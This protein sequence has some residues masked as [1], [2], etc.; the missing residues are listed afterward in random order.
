MA[1]AARVAPISQD[2]S[3]VE[4]VAA[5]RRGSDVAFEELYSRYSHR[6]GGYV[7]GMVGDRGRAE[8]ITQE[9]FIAAVRRMRETDRP[10]NFKAWI[11]EIAKN[12]CI[13]SFRRTRRTQ[14]VSLDADHGLSSADRG[15]LTVVTTPDSAFDSKQALQDLRGAFGGLSESHHEILVLRELEGRSYRDIGERLGMSR[16]M[17]ESTLFRA[18]RRLAEEYDEL[19]SGRRCEFVRTM[20]DSGPHYSLGIRDRRRIARH[21]AHCQPCRA[22]ARA[23]DFDESILNMPS[24]AARIAALLPIPLLRARWGGVERLGSS[25]TRPSLLALRSVHT[26]ARSSDQIVASTGAGRSAAAAAAI[27]LAGVGGGIVSET[28]SQPDKSFYRV[29]VHASASFPAAFK[30]VDIKLSTGMTV[31]FIDGGVM[32]NTPT[33]SSIGNERALDPMPDKRGITFVFEDKEGVSKGLLEGKVTPSQG[34]KA[35]LVDWFVG[36]SH[37]GAEYAKDRDMTDRPEE[38]V[39]VPLKV[40]LPPK[41]PGKKGKKVDMRDGTLEFNL[42]LEKKIA[43]QEATENATNEQIEREKQPKTRKFASDSQMF[44]SIGMSDLKALKASGY[45]GA[46]AAYD[47][48]EKVAEMIEKLR[49]AVKKENAK[50]QSRIANVLQDKDATMALDELDKLAGEDVD[51]Q[52]YVGRELNKGGLDSLLEAARKGGVKSGAM[53]ATYAVSDTLKARNFASNTLKNVI[54]PQMKVQGENG[55][56]IETLLVVE[57]LLR[58]AQTPEDVNEAL[59]IAVDHFK[60]KSDKLLPRKGHKQFAQRLESIM[61]PLAA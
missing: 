21:L 17:V 10:I 46:D 28:A 7:H 20:V 41:K 34:K 32:N 30:P 39:E 18:R 61:M 9:I 45:A 29:A 5:V 4:L 55:S 50:S 27:V 12:A 23:A 47:F 38:I 40:R 25:H 49:E 35:R 6:I 53:D 8:D 14:E 19:V 11:Y 59:T 51:F 22:H 16:A 58:A 36:S 33:S 54:Y 44:V 26:L 52:G 56:G 2:W 42:S 31:R 60:N 1:T 48:R 57:G 15:R 43:L 3:D 37:K 13:D 24:V